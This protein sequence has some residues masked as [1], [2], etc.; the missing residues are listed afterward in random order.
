VAWQ[1]GCVFVWRAGAWFS[2]SFEYRLPRDSVGSVSSHDVMAVDPGSMTMPRP[3]M[4]CSP[5]VIRVACVIT[6]PMNVIRP[7]ANL[8]RDR[9]RITSI[10]GSA[11]IGSTIIRSVPRVG[12]IIPF[13]PRYTERG[14]DQNKHE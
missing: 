11:V 12:A 2:P 14:G 4:T 5:G 9:A 1:R 13:A 8:D 3:P 10:I 7:I 6:R